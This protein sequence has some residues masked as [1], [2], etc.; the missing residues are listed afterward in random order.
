MT[1][2][3]VPLQSPPNEIPESPTQTTTVIMN[4]PETWFHLRRRQLPVS[5]SPIAIALHVSEQLE[6]F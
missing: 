3:G 6:A 4:M 1:D 2:G 5:C